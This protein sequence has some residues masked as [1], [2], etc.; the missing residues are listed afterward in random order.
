MWYLAKNATPDSE[1][2]ADSGNGNRLC[3][4]SAL[5]MGNT[6]LPDLILKQAVNI[7]PADNPGA[8]SG[9]GGKELFKSE[10]FENGYEFFIVLVERK[11]VQIR[12]KPQIILHPP[13]TLLRIIFNVISP[14]G[15]RPPDEFIIFNIISLESKFGA[16]AQILRGYFGPVFK[17]RQLPPAKR[18]SF[19]GVGS[20]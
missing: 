18:F 12:S 19:A 14:F 5:L 11:A 2:H 8:F 9:P 1:N 17:T 4:F 6:F 7:H 20:G 15:F 10:G 3:F 16:N 13:H